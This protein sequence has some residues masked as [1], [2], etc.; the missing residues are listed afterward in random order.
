MFGSDPG[1][2]LKV[3]FAMLGKIPYKNVIAIE[4]DE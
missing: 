2:I 4:L 3:S 1:S